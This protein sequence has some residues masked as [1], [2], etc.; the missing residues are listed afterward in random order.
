MEGYQARKKHS[1]EKMA[2]LDFTRFGSDDGRCFAPLFVQMHREIVSSIDN[3]PLYYFPINS[4]GTGGVLFS[5]LESIEWMPFEN[6]TDYES[7]LNR[8][9]SMPIQTQQFINVMKDGI[10]AGIV[11][12]TAM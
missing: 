10:K 2:K 5:C 6:A 9:R 3:C 7:L 1:Q 12:S 4:M 8:L 11:A